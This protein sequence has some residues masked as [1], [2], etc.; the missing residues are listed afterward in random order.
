MK[1]FNVYVY[2]PGLEREVLAENVDAKTALKQ[3]TE[4]VNSFRARYG[5]INII[6]I[7]DNNEK[8]IAEW[9]YPGYFMKPDPDFL[10]LAEK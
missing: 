9:N 2:Q 4:Q 7:T 6:T 1:T 8:I 5:I 3:F 10:E